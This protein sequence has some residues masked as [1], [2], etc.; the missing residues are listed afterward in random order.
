[1]TKP[2][3]PELPTDRFTRNQ[4]IIPQDKLDALT[5]VGLGGSGSNAIQLGS[6][7]GFKSINAFDGDM[8]E[9]HN[10]ST[11][12]YPKTDKEN[13]PKALLAEQLA[14][15]H[16][17]DVEGSLFARQ[18]YRRDFP[19][20]PITLLCTDTMESRMLVFEEW[21][22]YGYNKAGLF[23][24]SRMGALTCEVITV[25]GK[26]VEKAYR[27]YWKTSDEIA[28]EACTAKHTIFTGAIVA[29]MAM[30]QIQRWLIGAPY[31][32]YIRYNIDASQMTT[33]NQVLNFTE[34]KV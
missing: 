25:T 9:T 21:L 16:G 17:L 29:G 12:V 20:T 11:T 27:S 5:V 33:E 13:Q 31:F 1:M 30:A 18:H 7:M 14:A 24:D 34:V 22:K 32:T 8:M 19:L 26:D 3:K 4:D 6:I 10:I 2:G 28:D 15:S 23:V